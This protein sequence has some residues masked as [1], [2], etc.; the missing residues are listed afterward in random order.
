MLLNI[1]VNIIYII[2]V[3]VVTCVPVFVLLRLKE[4]LASLPSVL[5]F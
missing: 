5:R 2:I 3:I 4:V 1:V